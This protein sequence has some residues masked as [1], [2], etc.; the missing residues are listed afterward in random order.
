MLVRVI[1]SG[2]LITSF[3]LGKLNGF[4]TLVIIFWASEHDDTNNGDKGG[5]DV[6][7][8]GIGGGVYKFLGTHGYRTANYG[9]RCGVSG[10]RSSRDMVQRFRKMLGLVV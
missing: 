3:F 5:L 7:N 10:S 6:L 8:G 4:Q 9:R 1:Y 2:G